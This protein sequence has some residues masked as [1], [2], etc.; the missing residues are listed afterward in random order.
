[1]LDFLL[2]MPNSFTQ[3]APTVTNM[4]QLYLG[5][6][7]SDNYQVT[8]RFNIQVGLRWEP[9]LS[10]RD[11]HNDSAAWFSQAAYD[12]GTTSKVF[13]SAPPGVFYTGDAGYP[14]NGR[15]FGKVTLP[16]P[17]V[18]IVWDPTGSGKQT[19]RAGYGMFYDMTMTFYYATGSSDAPWASQVSIANPTGGFTNPY[20]GFTGGNPFPL[21]VPSAHVSFPPL[22]TYA[23]IPA[24]FSPANT[25]QWDLSYENQI[26]PNWLLSATFIGNKSTDISVGNNLNPAVYIPGTCGSGPCSTLANTQSRRVL[27]LINPTAGNLFSSVVSPINANAEYSGLLLSAK[28]RFSKNYTFLANYTW[29]HCI[30]EG[31]FAGAPGAT[32]QNTAN[33]FADR[34]NCGFDLRHIANLTFT[35]NSPKFAGQWTDRLLGNWQL[36]PILAVHSG[37][38]FTPTMGGVDNSLTSNGLDRPNSVSGVDSYV[39]NMSTLQWLN[40]AAFTANSTGTFGTAGMSSLAGPGYFDVDASVSRYFAVPRH[41]NQRFELRFEF[42]NLFNH[43]N[44]ATPNSTETSSKLGQI[45]SA[46]DPR[47]LEFA[48]KYSF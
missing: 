10:P 6:Y 44:F 31:D 29:S 30:D 32:F 41:E 39:K 46:A 25:Q 7:V 28:H 27:S 36:A 26:T 5:A 15:T 13:V 19:I 3:A 37:T 33:A 20:Q 16:E 1:M 40:P 43:A 18:G 23:F 22:V 9:Y 45:Q 17:R 47:I 48:M 38:W 8:K 11:I 21:P 35:A 2:G 42:F 14:G 4:R 12:A 24:N 34:G